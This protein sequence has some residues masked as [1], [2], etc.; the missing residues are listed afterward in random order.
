MDMDWR[1]ESKPIVVIIGHEVLEA[2][3]GKNQG[4]HAMTTDMIAQ[5]ISLKKNKFF[6]DL[7]E[8]M[9]LE[10]TQVLKVRE[11]GELIM[12]K[13]GMA[14]NMSVFIEKEELNQRVMVGK[15]K[16]KISG[17]DKIQN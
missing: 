9:G 16:M 14:T 15:G 6:L 8:N 13:A 3:A 11:S 12:I 5:S 17:V 7:L 4:R 1:G 10:K 2:G